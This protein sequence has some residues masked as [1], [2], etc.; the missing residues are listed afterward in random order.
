MCGLHHRTLCLSVSQSVTY[1]RDC[2]RPSQSRVFVTKTDRIEMALMQQ[3][4]FCL[5]FGT[6]V[7]TFLSS[8][9][10]AQ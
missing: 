8:D 1:K 2:V 5:V 4:P 7:I 9:Q 10:H 6:T 3:T